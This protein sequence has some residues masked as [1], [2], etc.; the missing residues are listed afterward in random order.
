MHGN[1]VLF[2][3][4]IITK[5]GG[6]STVTVEPKAG[7][8]VFNSKLL[9]PLEIATR[10]EDPHDKQVNSMLK[11][12][13]FNN[14]F[15][16]NNLSTQLVKSVS[17]SKGQSISLYKVPMDNNTILEVRKVQDKDGNDFIKIASVDKN[18]G[19]VNGYVTDPNTGKDWNK[20]ADSNGASD[21]AKAVMMGILE[22]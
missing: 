11:V 21:A 16:D 18:T 4:P 9:K 12:A 1:R 2:E 20:S 5:G 15:K 7:M 19:K 14:K 10:T 13:L 8:S 3:I 22:D 6:T 17:P